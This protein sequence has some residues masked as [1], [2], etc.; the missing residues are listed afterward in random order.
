MNYTYL[1]PLINTE[2]MDILGVSVSPYT[3]LVGDYF[4]VIFGL[5]PVFIMYLKSQD[6]AIPLISGLL[7]TAAFGFAFPENIGVAI[8]MLLGTCIGAIMFQVFKGRG[9]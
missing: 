5:I 1:D 8:I 9:D 7:F 3:A 6:S 2:S 4:Y